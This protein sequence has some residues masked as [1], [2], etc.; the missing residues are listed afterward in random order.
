MLTSTALVIE[1]QE[2]LDS[3]MDGRPWRASKFAATLR[4]Q[5]TRKHLGLLSTQDFTK[6]DGNFYPVGVPNTYQYG[7]AE[8]VLVTDPI[9]AF[10]KVF[11]PI[12]DDNVETWTDYDNFYEKYFHDAGE[13]AEGK[14]EEKP[15]TYRWG[16]VVASEF[17]PGEQGVKEMKNALARIRGTVVEMP[18][19]FLIREDIARKGL[20]LNALTEEIY[21]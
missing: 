10:R 18:L 15:G 17:S 19:L 7:T 11:H 20:S 5:L 6:P 9:A 2:L 8:D 21:T 3:Y 13:V 4:R 16:H 1:D 12:P 14:A